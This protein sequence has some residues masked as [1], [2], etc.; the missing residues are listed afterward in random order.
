MQGALFFI[1][2]CAETIDKSLDPVILIY[3]HILFVTSARDSS[4]IFS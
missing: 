2:T 3:G 1:T 4:V